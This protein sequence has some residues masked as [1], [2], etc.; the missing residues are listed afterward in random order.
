M[1]RRINK[2]APQLKDSAT[3]HARIDSAG[4]FACAIRGH[5]RRERRRRRARPAKKSLSLPVV[6][7]FC[8]RTQTHPRTSRCHHRLR[9]AAGLPHGACRRAGS[10]PCGRWPALENGRRWLSACPQPRR[11]A[12]SVPPRT[13]LQVLTNASRSGVVPGSRFWAEAAQNSKLKTQYPSS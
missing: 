3:D 13:S 5:G 8:A 6:E 12:L 7:P 4:A 9:P 1:P 2:K 10:A 11:A